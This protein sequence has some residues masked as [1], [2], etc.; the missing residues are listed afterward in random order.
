MNDFTI[1]GLTISP[2]KYEQLLGIPKEKL[3]SWLEAG[4][5]ILPNFVVALITLLMFYPFA[6][7]AKWLAGKLYRKNAH[8]VAL[9]GLVLNFV[10]LIVFFI[11]LFSA[12][13]ILNLEKTV[14]SLLA[15]AGVIGLALGLAFQEIASNFVSG[16]LIASR[17]PYGIGDIIQI[18][19][20]IGSVTSIDLRTTSIMTG[21]GLEVIVPNKIMITEPMINYTST[22]G[23]RVEIVVGVAYDS[24][25]KKVETITKEAIKNLPQLLPNRDVEFYYFE[26]AASSINFKVRFWIDFPGD[27]N[28]DKSTHQAIINIKKTFDD[29]GIT[30]PFP[31]QTAD[32]SMA[33][34]QDVKF[35]Q[36]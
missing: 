14:T 28:F 5:N 22:P 18:Q 9:H 25:L 33:I 30:I 21:Q 10:F 29:H 31:I 35:A 17:K 12:L 32:M 19:G 1:F 3:F 16:V 23:R 34:K 26:F 7:L 13:E 6:K 20:H 4:L 15:G 36:L 24:D 2:E 11:G 8:N 27:M